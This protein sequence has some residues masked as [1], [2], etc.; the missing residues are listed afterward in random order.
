MDAWWD[1]PG[2]PLTNPSDPEGVLERVFRPALGD[3]RDEGGPGPDRLRRR[4]AQ[5]SGDHLGSA[6]HDGWYGLPREGPAHTRSA[7]RCRAPLSRRYCGGDQ[8]TE[9]TLASC[10]SVLVDSLARRDRRSPPPTSTRPTADC[11]APPTTQMCFDAVRFRTVG[12]VSVDPI[13]WINRP[14]WQQVVEVQG[15]RPRPGGSAPGACANRLGGTR[16]ADRIFGTPVGDRIAGRR[17]ADRLFGLAGRDCVLGQRGADR[18]NGGK[19]KDVL[20]G[21]GGPDRVRARDGLRDRIRCG[22][23]L[24]RVSADPKDRVAP[25]CERRA[26]R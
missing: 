23:G 2:D 21:G 6:Y 15:H 14:T 8:N 18:I 11:G 22:P 7:S 20:R 17:G 19:G 12:A 26:R 3:D 9:G 1:P 25:S 4:A 5:R 24:D 13:H 10:Q 16:G